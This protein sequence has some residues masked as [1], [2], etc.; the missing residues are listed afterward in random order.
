VRKLR[1]HFARHGEWWWVPLLYA[2]AVMWIYRGLWHQHGQAYGLGWDTIDSYGPD[3]DFFSREVR[4]GRFSLWNPY[5]KGGYPLFCDPQIDRYYPFNWPFAAWGAVFGSSW[6]LIQIKV[7]AHHVVA[8]SGMHLFLRSRG[9]GVRPALIGSLALVASAPM[10]VHKASIILWPLVWVPLVWVAIDAAVQKPSWRRGV[11]V[12]AALVLPVT[13]A[14]PPGLFYAALLVTPYAAFRTYKALRDGVDR[15]KLAECVGVA[16]AVLLPVLALVIMPS[17]EL[18]ALGSRDRFGSGRDFAL[19]GGIQIFRELRGVFVRGAG[20]FEVYMGAGAVMLAAIGLVV[21]PHF[22]RGAAIVL[23]AIAAFG[24]VLAAGDT[25]PILPLLV[26]HVPGFELLRVPGRYKLVTAFAIAAGAGYGAA[27][28]AGAKTRVYATAGALLALCVVFVVVWGN[29]ETPKDRAAWWSIAATAIAAALV[30]AATR[31][32]LREVALAVLAAGVLLDA[33]TFLFVEPGAPPAG[34]PRQLHDHDAELVAKMPGIRDKWRMYDEFV[35][36]ERAGARLRVRDFRGYPAIDPLSLHRYTDVIDFTALD[37]AILTDFNV[38]WLLVR[39]HFRDPGATYVRLPNPAFE[40][41]DGGLYEA[42]H[43]APLIQWYGAG[44][45]VH[46]PKDV[47]PA[48]RAVA[49]PDGS[50]RRVILE[51]DARVPDKFFQ[52]PPAGREGQLASYDDDE[53]SFRIDAPDD[54]LVV[55]NEIMFPGWQVTVDGN[56]AEPVRAN[57]LLRGVWVSAGP[58]LVRWKFEPAHWRVLIGGYL[59]AL[60]VIAAAGASLLVSRRR[61]ARS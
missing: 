48:V 42:I 59:L 12:A 51:P 37:T 53:I 5:D 28:L 18:V 17:R 44:Q 10:L 35:L 38:R 26:D 24:I 55:L 47:L 1:D 15:L 22:D 57:Y 56:A 23:A 39:G 34:E 21:R 50:R 20:P 9:L 43:P 31:R 41:H 45:L 61:A 11:G 32:R 36:G 60:A 16:I 25:T 52:A 7:L 3:L 13:A 14:S 49:E 19:A 46:E 27:A 58:H 29:P 40:A 33:P 4:E 30:I 6:W 54:G 8:A 2:L